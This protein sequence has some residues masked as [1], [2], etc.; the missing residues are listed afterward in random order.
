V[1]SVSAA[2]EIVEDRY[3]DYAT[4]DTPTLIAD[5]FFGAGCVLGEPR[6]DW[7]SLDL[8]AVEATMSINGEHVGNGVGFDILGHPLEALRWLATARA[9]RGFPLRA[10]EFVLLGSLV[11][12]NWVER[13]DEILVE[14]PQFASV[15]A[16]IV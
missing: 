6:T 14:S 2:I 5:D 8:A 9:G 10:G 16:R 15:D 1:S 7:Q 12:T 4:L 13:G 3:V 11:Q